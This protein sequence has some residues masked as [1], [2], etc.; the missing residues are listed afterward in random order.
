MMNSDIEHLEERADELE[1]RLQ[2]I[3]GDFRRGLER[4]GQDRHGELENS[5][6]L[7]EIGRSAERELARIRRRLAELRRRH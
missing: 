6:G 3:R 4:H 7:R 2:A 1:Y 5:A